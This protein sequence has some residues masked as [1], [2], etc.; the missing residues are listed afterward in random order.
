MASTAQKIDEFIRLYDWCEGTFNLPIWSRPSGNKAP[1]NSHKAGSGYDEHCK[2]LVDEYRQPESRAAAERSLEKDGWNL[3]L[4]LD[5]IFVI[6]VDSEA[7]QAFFNENLAHFGE[8]QVCPL[9]KTRKGHHYMLR[10]PEACDIVYKAR[11]ILDDDGNVQEIDIITVTGAGD[12]RTRGNLAVYPSP[13]KTWVRSIYDTEMPIMSDELHEWLK[14]HY[15]YNSVTK[16]KVARSVQNDARER[17]TTYLAQHTECH[18]DDIIWE[19]VVSGR[20]N[21]HPRR[22]IAD[23]SHM[24]HHDNA[25]FDIMENGNLQYRC[26]SACCKKQIVLVDGKGGVQQKDEIECT[27]FGIA[28]FF[29]KHYGDVFVHHCETLYYFNGHTWQNDNRTHMATKYLSIHL[30]RKYND[31]LHKARS[32]MAREMEEADEDAVKS[33]KERHEAVIK[34]LNSCLHALHTKKRCESVLKFVRDLLDVDEDKITWDDCNDLLPFGDK[35]IDLKNRN[36]DGSYKVVKSTPDMYIRTTTGYSFEDADEE[37][38]GQ[39]E[40]MMDQIFPDKREKELF[41]TVLASGLTGYTLDRFTI[42]NGEGSNGKS[43]LMNLMKEAAGNFAHCL[44]SKV[45]LDEQ[46]SGATPELAACNGKRYLYCSEP[47][48]NKTIK[49]ALVKELTGETEISARMLY[50]NETRVRLHSTIVMMC[51]TKPLLDAEDNQSVRR[52]ILD[53]LFRSTFV[54]ADQVDEYG[55]NAFAKDTRYI[56]DS[57]MKEYRCQFVHLLAGYVTKFYELNR[58]ISSLIPESVIERSKAYISDSDGFLQWFKETYRQADAAEMK[59]WVKISVDGTEVLCEGE[60]LFMKCDDIYSTYKQGDYF[61]S[62]SKLNQRQQNRRW[63]IEKMSTHIDLRKYFVS[64]HRCHVMDAP[65]SSCPFRDS[66]AVI[67]SHNGQIASKRRIKARN[68]IKG[69][70]QRTGREEE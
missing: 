31:L 28:S 44:P 63:F 68:I 53:V 56:E 61:R 41:L 62:L 35:V 32:D 20:I 9:A 5:D 22:C 37:K 24:S 6:D 43:V 45:I 33:I 1:V 70:V 17:Y 52:R 29:R 48:A 58:D 23:P 40:Q 25:V 60:K 19:S 21:V 4:L 39:L 26:L 15:K 34:T 18:V 27:D 69:W 30:Y 55:E 50:S 59:G 64:D 8:F 57:F 12:P 38:I 2:K 67:A 36:D 10:R 46:K 3:N 66:E 42:A 65:D 51:N 13:N 11:S 7:A 47:S 14:A 49:F 54:D 16:T